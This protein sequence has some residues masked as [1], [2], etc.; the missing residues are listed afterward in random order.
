MLEDKGD[1]AIQATSVERKNEMR[2]DFAPD[3]A[4]TSGPETPSDFG[5]FLA[6]CRERIAPER[7]CL[8]RFIIIG[9]MKSGTTSMRHI[10][11]RHENVFL[12]QDDICF[13]DLDDIEQ[14][15]D[16]FIPLPQGWTFHNFERD[17]DTYFNW[18]KNFFTE[19]R[20]GQ[21]IGENSCTY[22]ASKKA[23]KRIAGIFPDMKVIAMLRDPVSRAYSHY[24]HNLFAGRVTSTFE[25]TLRYDSGTYLSRGFYKEQLERYLTFFSREQLKIIV[26]EEFVRDKQASVDDLTRFIGLS[27]SIDLSKID[28][29]RNPAPVPL[30]IKGRRLF[31]MVV[32]KLV[33]KHTIR[34]LPNMPGFNPNVHRNT[35][36]KYP[37]L[38]GWVRKYRAYQA[39]K[40]KLPP[41]KVETRSFLEKLYRIENAG[42][43]DLLQVDLSEH[44][45]YMGK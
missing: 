9:A 33:D 35:D 23:P 13:F 38:S 41:M 30:S 20:A 1:C 29:H 14:H 2:Q 26:F 32:G 18:Y 36:D 45:P 6:D 42:L 43:T 3:P 15:K 10:L 27:S 31:N 24:W 4:R 25:E 34:N 37:L 12:P 22:L 21:A 11:S 40:R 5:G 16:Y 44:W 17:F 7:D 8:P 28:T 39:K 19:A